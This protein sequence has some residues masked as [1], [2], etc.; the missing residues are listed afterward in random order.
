MAWRRLLIFL[1][2]GLLLAPTARADIDVTTP[3]GTYYQPG[4]YVPVRV[5]LSGSPT[6]DVTIRAEGSVPTVVSAEALAGGRTV[7]VPFLPI[8]GAATQ[9]DVSAAGHAS[10]TLPLVRVPEGERLVAVMGGDA[11][12][13]FARRLFPGKRVLPVSGADPTTGLAVAWDALDGAVLDHMPEPA[14]VTALLAMGL[15]LAV[16]DPAAPRD[17]WP[18]Q[19]EGNYWVVRR[20]WCGPRGVVVPE[21]YDPPQMWHPGRPEGV[22]RGGVMGLVLFAL[23]ITGASLLRPR[24]AIAVIAGGSAVACIVGLAWRQRLSPVVEASGAVIVTS[25]VLT[26]RD[27]WIYRRHL[28]PT[29]GAIAAPSADVLLKPALATTR[30]VERAGITLRALSESDP[31]QF[32][33]RLEPSWTV[34][35][36]TTRI[37]P[38][39]WPGEAVKPVRTPMRELAPLYLSVSRLI[40]GELE[41]GVP[42]GSPPNVERW[43][44]LVISP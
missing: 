44:A 19:L 33:Y 38:G 1:L 27:D 6:S 31:P 9:F 26:Q 43:N 29:E 7:T 23:L 14:R 20:E 4:R 42:G 32:T 41:D 11:D 13:A 28:E 36:R 12:V 25:D 5:R 39:R 37:A 34:A 35:F 15:T 2:L 8:A 30:Q 21:A 17:A 18:W 16:R 24:W 10:R 3:L 22:R 40:A